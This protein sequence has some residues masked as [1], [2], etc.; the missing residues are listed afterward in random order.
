MSHFI[1]MEGI[2]DVTCT[3]Y[4]FVKQNNELTL[5]SKRKTFLIENLEI[6]N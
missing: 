1:D 4:R 5:I 3:N 6:F 2:C